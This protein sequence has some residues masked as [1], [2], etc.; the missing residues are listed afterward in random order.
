MAA[1]KSK[2]HQARF[3]VLDAAL[4]IE[5]G[6]SD[7]CD[8]LIFVD[9][10]KRIRQERTRLRRGWPAN[11]LNRRERFQ[12]PPDIKRQRANFIIYNNGTLRHLK[13]QTKEIADFI[14]ELSKQ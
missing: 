6:L 9:A 3:I 8:V 13:N 5:S 2:K 11:E 12:L 14:I 10:A 7:I 4:L 1:D